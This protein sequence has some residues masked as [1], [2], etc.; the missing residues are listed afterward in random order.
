M[1][2]WTMHTGYGDGTTFVGDTLRDAIINNM[3]S[4]HRAHRLGNAA[5]YVIDTMTM[6]Y[7]RGILGGKGGVELVIVHRGMDLAHRKDDDP[8]RTARIWIYAAPSD[9]PEPVTLYRREPV[10]DERFEMRVDS[11][12]KEWI[13]QQGGAEF[14]RRVLRERRASGGPDGVEAR[15]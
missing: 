7:Q 5:G 15:N 12:L 4:I 2:E 1:R 10:L 13:I 9:C 14:V 11:A 6:S 8:P 3:E